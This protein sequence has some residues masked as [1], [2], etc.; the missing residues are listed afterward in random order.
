MQL[1]L[2]PTLAI[3]LL[4]LSWA[5]SSTGNITT[6]QS[7]TLERTVD[8]KNVA[9]TLPSLIPQQTMAGV[10]SG[11]LEIRERFV[12]SSATGTV[13]YVQ[14]SVSAGV[15]LPAPRTLDINGTSYFVATLA[16][17]RISV[18]TNST[19]PSVQF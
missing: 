5:D 18:G 11:L 8:P 1:T 10:V 4:P 17:Q 14:F 16:V 6:V 2:V 7:L 19:Y 3:A 9:S 12:Y 13:N 15:P